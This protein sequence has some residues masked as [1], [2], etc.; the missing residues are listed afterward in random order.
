MRV[1]LR[2][3]N[4]PRSPWKR[5]GGR[6]RFPDVM[7][8]DQQTSHGHME[9]YRLRGHPPLQ[10]HRVTSLEQGN[11]ASDIEAHDFQEV[12]AGCPAEAADEI[13][14]DEPA[15]TASLPSSPPSPSPDQPQSGEVSQIVNDS[16]PVL[17]QGV[18][19][20]NLSA[21][22]SGMGYAVPG[23]YYP[24]GPWM[25]PYPQVLP[26][27]SF[28]HGHPQGPLAPPPF[29]TS[30]GPDGMG[31]FGNT[32]H[33]SAP[34]WTVP[35]MVSHIHTGCH[36]FMLKFYKDVHAISTACPSTSWRAFPAGTRPGSR[37]I[38]AHWILSG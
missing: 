23:A 20:A 3:C 19:D 37:T 38:V 7:Q 34:Y 5:S 18:Q 25:A 30:P 33:A 21:P 27:Q 11:P 22:E 1:Q 32:A 4:P 26:P 2:N 14:E 28:Y 12:E 31:T 17:Q 13:L 9:E 29:L 15:V 24:V 36:G 35:S 16:T 10:S 8:G 6:H